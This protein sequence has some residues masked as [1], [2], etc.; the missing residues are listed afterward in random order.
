MIGKFC[1]DKD[2]LPKGG[3]INGTRNQIYLWFKSDASNS[4]DGFQI[5]WTSSEPGIYMYLALIDI[6]R[7]LNTVIEPLVG[8]LL[9]SVMAFRCLLNMLDIITVNI[10]VYIYIN[11]E[12]E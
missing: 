3:V 10:H 6:N 12:R 9:V 4:G 2:T 5:H 7:V 8:F 1:G 11:M